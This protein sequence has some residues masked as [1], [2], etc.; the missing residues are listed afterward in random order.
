MQPITWSKE[1]F[2]SNVARKLAALKALRVSAGVSLEER[3]AMANGR[4]ANQDLGIT[5]CGRHSEPGSQPQWKETSMTNQGEPMAFSRVTDSDESEAGSPKDPNPPPSNTWF[6][7]YTAADDSF[8]AKTPSAQGTPAKKPKGAR[9][10][11]PIASDESEIAAAQ[12]SQRSLLEANLRQ[13]TA[14]W[15]VL[16]RST[17]LHQLLDHP[18]G[19]T[20]VKLAELLIGENATPRDTR[21]LSAMMTREEIRETVIR[22]GRGQPIVLTLAG[23]HE[24]QQLD[25]EAERNKTV[26]KRKRRMKTQGERLLRALGD[27]PTLKDGQ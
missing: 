18:K 10:P 16:D 20:L 7:G 12:A 25:V 27:D 21:R 11:E 23:K 15:V 17:V 1:E 22:A 19:L 14:G 9:R 5:N 13:S 2:A 3:L 6:P 4:I 8:G 26:E 24:L